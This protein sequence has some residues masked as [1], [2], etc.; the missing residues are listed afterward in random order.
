LKVVRNLE[1]YIVA[2][3]VALRDPDWRDHKNKKEEKK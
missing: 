2:P 1:E 3:P